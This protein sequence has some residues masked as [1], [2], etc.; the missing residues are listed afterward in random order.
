MG[1]QIAPSESAAHAA[2]IERVTVRTFASR[3]R[4]VIQNLQPFLGYLQLRHKKTEP[5]V[6]SS[7]IWTC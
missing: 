1:A 2:Q 5:P 7:A 4:G 3:I 6:G